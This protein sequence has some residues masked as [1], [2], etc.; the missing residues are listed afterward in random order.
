MRP[1]IDASSSFADIKQEFSMGTFRSFLGA[2][3]MG[4]ACAVAPGW[5]SAQSTPV[6][7]QHQA[8]QGARIANGQAT[9]QLSPREA[10]RLQAG[11]AKVAGMEAAAKADG[12]VTSAERA[13]VRSAQH[14]QNHRI[15]KQKHDHDNR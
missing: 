2:A 8:N 1:P 4:V 10:A 5:G 13:A 14:K 7:D 3:A 11:Q 9:G 15:R 6:I 12:Q